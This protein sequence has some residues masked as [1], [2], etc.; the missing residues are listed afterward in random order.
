MENNGS[1][2]FI[3]NTGS[4][5]YENIILID[6]PKL[7]LETKKLSIEEV[8]CINRQRS[9]YIRETKKKELE[10]S[11]NEL[12]KLYEEERKKKIK[13]DKHIKK[14]HNKLISPPTTPPS[15]PSNDIVYNDE[16]RPYPLQMTDIIQPMI[17]HYQTNNIGQLIIPPGTGKTLCSLF[18]IKIQI[19]KKIL[20]G[21]PNTLLLKQW[22]KEINRI[23]NCKVII[24]NGNSDIE[25]VK[26][27][28]ECNDNI[29]VIT[30]Y[31]SCNKLKDIDTIWDFKI[32]D[33]CHHLTGV[34]N[35]M[36]IRSYKIFLELS[37]SKTLYMTATRKLVI[38]TNLDNEISS[39]GNESIFGK[40][41][42]K[43]KTILW[44]IN[45]KLITDYNVII[46]KNTEYE[47]DLLIKE[48]LIDVENE[49]ERELFVAA[50]ETVKCILNDDEL[51]DL[52]HVLVYTN[53]IEN[54]KKI[55]KY[56]GEILEK[57]PEVKE[58]IYHKSLSS[59]DDV[60][61]DIE[62]ED[63]EINTFIKSKYGIISC[64][65]LF[66]EGVDIP[67]LNGEVYAENM[68]AE[69]RIVQSATRA[70][71]KDKSFPDKIAYILIPYLIGNDSFINEENQSFQKLREIIYHIGNQDTNIEQKI[72]LKDINTNN[73]LTLQKAFNI[74]KRL[75][76]SEYIG[77]IHDINENL[78]EMLKLKL[79]KRKFLDTNL[80]ELNIENLETIERNKLFNLCRP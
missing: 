65:Y 3:Y 58:D 77:G 47:I 11:Y 72:K 63:S 69:T 70:M 1:D 18:F 53:S 12:L 52:T 37:S 5:I 31:Q 39:M 35:K 17:Y 30:T 29:F 25:K 79:K 40:I 26:K 49:K 45:N 80:D 46:L 27:Q 41:I 75:I 36:C 42:V 43:N 38:Y 14:R 68:T 24:F 44:A 21:V 73:E 48:Y 28:I 59:E 32:G 57:F 67:K 56:I 20:I 7:G 9:T 54:S 19:Y 55:N 66:G 16:L 76:K 50:I 22:K 13:R 15:L 8:N 51:K 71:R 78:L 10:D 33:E 34:Y 64:V 62:H 74:W 2:E 4:E 60:D 23:F 6:F 61:L